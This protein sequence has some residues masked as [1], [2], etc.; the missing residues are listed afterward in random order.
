[1]KRKESF[2]REKKK[3]NKFT[4][5]IWEKK[6]IKE[7]NDNNNKK[8]INTRR[9]IFNGRRKQLK[10]FLTDILKEM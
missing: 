8:H 5:H 7:M 10:I 9:N 2:K 6:T 1:M 4:N 3:D